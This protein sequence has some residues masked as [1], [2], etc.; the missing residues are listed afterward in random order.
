[1]PETSINQ[2]D[3]IEVA[4]GS[5]KNDGGLETVFNINDKTEVRFLRVCFQTRQPLIVGEIE[6][7]GE[8]N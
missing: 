2:K 7:F 6:V 3:W 4:K 8:T 1:M 5:Y